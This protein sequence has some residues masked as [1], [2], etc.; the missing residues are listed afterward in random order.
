MCLKGE[1]RL[2]ARPLDHPCKTRRRE[3]RTTF[4]GEDEGGL[5]LLL[6]VKP[7]QCPQLVTDDGV[8]PSWFAG[9]AGIQVHGPSAGPPVRRPSSR[10]GRPPGS[11]WRPGDCSVF[12]APCYQCFW[13]CLD[14]QRKRLA[15]ARRGV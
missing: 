8:N 5:E 9:L 4:R 14:Q 7:A 3:G 2:R 11:S 12:T 6:A 1:P 13:H 15:E 10:A